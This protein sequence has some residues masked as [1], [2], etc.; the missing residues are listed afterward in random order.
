MKSLAFIPDPGQPA[1]P[2]SLL[3]PLPMVPGESK[4]TLVA[5]FEAEESRILGFAIGLVGRRAIAEELVQETF[6]RLHQVWDQVEHPRAWLYRSLRNLAANHLRDRKEETE[7]NEE[8]DSDPGEEGLPDAA[9]GRMEAVGT[10]H[11]LMADLAP[12][13]RNL[14]R[15]KYEEGLRYREISERTGLSVGNVGY[16]LHHLLKELAA[17]LRQA[18]IEGS[19]G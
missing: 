7:L 6:V 17:G 9:L 16:R 2:R 18:G 3:I 13:D 14:I 12:E 19:R 4:P 15:L 11:L 10:M 5:L 1:D 8:R